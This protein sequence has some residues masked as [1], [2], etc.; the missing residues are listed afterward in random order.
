MFPEQSAGKSDAKTQQTTIC[1]R[2]SAAVLGAGAA[3]SVSI[4]GGAIGNWIE[5]QWNMVVISWEMAGLVVCVLATLCG[6]F[7]AAIAGI[8]ARVVVGP[9]LG[10][11]GVGACLAAISLTNG[12]PRGVAI[13]SIAVGVGAGMA[14]GAVGGMIGKQGQSNVA[15][16]DGRDVS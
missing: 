10:A 7:F 13:W 4:L 2:S 1:T 15:I 11:V 6:F 5:S 3:F 9:V 8:F 14:A 12:S 16:N